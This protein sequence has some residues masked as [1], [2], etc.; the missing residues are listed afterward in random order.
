MRLFSSRC[1]PGC[2]VAGSASHQC[3]QAS[4]NLLSTDAPPRWICAQSERSISVEGVLRITYQP[5]ALFRVRPVTRCSSAMEGALAPQPS[6][7]SARAAQRAHH[8][9]ETRVMLSILRSSRPPPQVTRRQSCAPRSAQ[10]GSTWRAPPPLPTPLPPHPAARGQTHAHVASAHSRRLIACL[11]IGPAG[12][13]QRGHDRPLLQPESGAPSSR[14]Q[15]S[16][17]VRFSSQ[18][19][20]SL[21]G[22]GFNI[23]RPL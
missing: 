22:L 8:R 20:A 2:S 21:Y 11:S 1:P 18:A 6:T 17:E 14:R 10:M 7:R 19:H 5:Q 13:R 23:K 4:V 12:E 16:Q 9:F 3:Q 15:G